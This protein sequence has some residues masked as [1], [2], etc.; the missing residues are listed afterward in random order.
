MRLA[1]F[2]ASLVVMRILKEARGAASVLQPEDEVLR[3]Q[4][5]SR[6]RGYSWM[7]TLIEMLR[8]MVMMLMMMVMLVVM[9]VMLMLT[10]MMTRIMVKP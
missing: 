1:R 4:A 2:M 6:S 9:M 7:L 8:M 10:V 3:N 5:F